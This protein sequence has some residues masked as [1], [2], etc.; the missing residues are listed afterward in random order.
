MSRKNTNDDFHNSPTCEEEDDD[1]DEEWADEQAENENLEFFPICS[2]T[3][4]QQ[5]LVAALDHDQQKHKFNLLEYLPL[6][7]DEEFFEKTIVCINKARL[8]VQSQSR[9]NEEDIGTALAEYLKKEGSGSEEEDDAQFFKP[10]L[11]DDHMIMCMD[12]LQ[13][14]LQ[15]RK[16][17]KATLISGNEE[18]NIDKND[19]N[20]EESK[21]QLKLKVQALEEQLHRAKD[22]ITKL[23]D[24]SDTGKNDRAT[25]GRK[26]SERDNDTYYFSSYSHSSIHETMLQDTIRTKAYQDAILSN[27]QMFKDKVVMD[28]GC[29]TGILSLFAAQAGAKKVI[30]IDAS[31]VHTQARKIVELNKY[32][33]IIHVVHGKVENL[34]LNKTLP[35][36]DNE[37]VDVVIS[38]WMGYALLYETMLPSVLAARDEYMDKENGTMWPNKSNMFIEGATDSRLEYWDNVYGFDMTPMKTKVVKELCNEATVEINDAKTVVTNRAE[39]ISFDLNICNDEDLDFQ[40]NFELRKNKS[41]AQSSAKVDKLVISFDV[42]FDLREYTKASFSTSCQ[43][44]PTHWKQTALWFDPADAPSLQAGEVLK[45]TLHMARNDRNQRDMD[46]IV[47]WEIGDDS[48]STFDPRVKGTITSKLSS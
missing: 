21:V 31:D 7:E 25:N 30:A 42:D 41:N 11:E 28:I 1:D 6:V 22:Y 16:D 18:Q 24:S 44:E 40:A 47:T 4:P 15:S 14:L 46:F 26:G 17:M 23:T 2:P 34:I 33:S 35:L 20:S 3:E 43:T 37:R 9:D 27:K 12:D 32:D 36:D 39:L 13:D 8:F 38:E 29:G 5:S 45:G 10:V 48:A 19:D